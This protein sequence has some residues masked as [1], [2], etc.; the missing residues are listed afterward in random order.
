M[1]EL[2]ETVC[3]SLEPVKKEFNFTFLDLFDSP[4]F[5]VFDFQDYD[6]L[7]DKG[8]EKLSKIIAELV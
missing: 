6:H 1:P 2:R 7:N 5:D 4:D 3:E 8:A